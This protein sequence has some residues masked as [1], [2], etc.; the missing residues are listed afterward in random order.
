MP[1]IRL[2]FTAI[3]MTIMFHPGLAFAGEL[4][5]G[6]ILVG[7]HDDK[8]YSQA[9]YEGA[10]YVEANLSGTR[11]I[12][13]D[14]FNPTDRPDLTVAQVAA[15]MISKGAGLIIAG[16][17]DMKDG[18][19]E[20]AAK[21][22]DT[23]FIHISGDSV[24]TG[25]APANLGNLF[26]RMHYSKMM[27]G[28]TAAMTTDTG[29]I[30]VLGPLVNDET[31]R[32]VDS[33]YLGAAHAWTVVR[34]KDIRD[35][36]FK[37]RWIG[38]WFN[39]PGLTADPLAVANSLFDSGYDVIISGID[40]PEAVSVARQ[41]REQGARVFALPYNY[42][43]ACLD[44]GEAC[45]GVPYFNWGPSFLRI[46]RQVQTGTY[47][48]CFEWDSPYWADINDHNKSTIGFRPGP[49]MSPATR[50]K[51]NTFTRQLGTGEVDLFTGPL[52]YQ[53]GSL[54]L[55]KGMKAT[56]RQVWYMPQLLKGMEGP[57]HAE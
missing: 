6:L 54:F 38:F 16:S 21:H 3:L 23:T 12:F 18:V 26:G 43:K 8:G 36:R 48:S 22:P 24:W 55:K 5:I 29:K 13:L 50:A 46:A 31:R 47:K 11:L 1:R 28:F 7:P 45:L 33:A 25:E 4:T 9:Q 27:A 51:L 57:S 37:V 32:M 30:A 41:R 10:R 52:A 53:D 35:L 2:M 44:Q 17:D 40:T 42:E 49:G 56:D 15:D 14:E 19:I 39:I 20:A 34:G